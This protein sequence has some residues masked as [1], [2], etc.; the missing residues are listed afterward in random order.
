MKLAGIEKHVTPHTFRHTYASQR[1]QTVT[2][3]RLPGGEEIWV[4]VPL[5]EVARELG[6]TDTGLVE[7]LYGHLQLQ[8]DRSTV[9][10]YRPTRV[11]ELPVAT[12][13]GEGA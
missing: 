13:G 1:V 11:L 8:P 9:V 7:R 3:A 4:P 12:V 2:R 10:E 5:M 6:H